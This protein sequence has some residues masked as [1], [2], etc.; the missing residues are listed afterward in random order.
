MTTSPES[1]N[2]KVVIVVGGSRGLGRGIVE[3]F[4][5][6]GARVYALGRDEAALAA[7]ANH[8][9]GIIPIRGEATDEAAAEHLLRQHDPDVLVICAGASPVLAPLFEQT[10]EDFCTNWNV[11]TKSAFVWLRQALRV[12]MKK[13]GHIIVV[14]SGA[15]LRGSPVS[16][17][18]AGAKRAQWFIADYAATESGRGGLGL[19]IHCV[20]PDLNPSTELG[21]AGIAAYAK[22]MGVAPEE[23]AKRFEPVLTPEIM[24]AGVT[25]LVEHPE[26][27]SQLAYRIGGSGLS[28]LT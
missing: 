26:K 3:S 27:W 15:A 18:Y 1:G 23:F 9:L 10:W 4:A 12:P 6:G 16:G 14:S 28:P 24:G 20:L 8:T 17:G 22:R 19:R 25:E 13:G 5:K 11:D 2:Q 21:R 7:L